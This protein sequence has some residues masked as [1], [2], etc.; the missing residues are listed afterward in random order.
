MLGAC[1]KASHPGGSGSAP[2]DPVKCQKFPAHPFFLGRR[3]RTRSRSHSPPPHL[4]GPRAGRP[5]PPLPSAPGGR[6]ALCGRLCRRWSGAQANHAALDAIQAFTGPQIGAGAG[7]E[8]LKSCVH[9]FCLCAGACQGVGSGE[10]HVCTVKGSAPFAWLCVKQAAL[11]CR[12]KPS[13]LGVG[14]GRRVGDGPPPPVPGTR[15]WAGSR[16]FVNHTLCRPR[17]LHPAARCGP[18]AGWLRGQ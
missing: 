12:L 10:G 3:G 4:A 8:T 18:A 1:L 13:R 7:E 16:C 15:S 9:N 14:T 11:M 6:P 17:P 2:P 5:Q